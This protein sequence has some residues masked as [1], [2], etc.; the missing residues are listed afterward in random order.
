MFGPVRE[1]GPSPIGRRGVDLTPGL[2]PSEHNPRLPNPNL[3]DLVAVEPSL[4]AAKFVHGG[5]VVAFELLQRSSLLREFHGKA[6]CSDVWCCHDALLPPIELPHE[7]DAA[8]VLGLLVVY[9]LLV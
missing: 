3:D 6:L 7:R 1:P 5:L 2:K 9:R 4:M 8:V